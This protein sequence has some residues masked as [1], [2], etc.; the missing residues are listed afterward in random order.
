[1]YIIKLLYN[2]NE[3]AIQNC[4][5]TLRLLMMYHYTKSGLQFKKLKKCGRKIFFKDLTLHCD[6]DL[7]VEDRNPT[8]SHDTLCHD[9]APWYQVAYIERLSG[10][11]NIIQINIPGG[12]EP[13]LW[14]YCQDSNPKLPYSTPVYDDAPLYQIWMKSFR[15]SGD[16]EEIVGF[17]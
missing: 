8:F 10:S 1:M 3:I 7:E 4:H 17:F 9:D 14:P 15:R 5:T 16:T 11:E 12:F 13:S 2:W 6:L